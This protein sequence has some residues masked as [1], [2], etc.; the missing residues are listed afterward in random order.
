METALRTI[1]V[2]V[3]PQLRKFGKT[4]NSHQKISS[5]LNFNFSDEFCNLIE[6]LLIPNV[7][8]NVENN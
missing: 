2:E 6:S 4:S 7:C 3:G 8:G 1:L 5:K